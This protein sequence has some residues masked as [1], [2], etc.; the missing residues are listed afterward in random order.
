MQ[1]VDPE[2]CELKR[3][4]AEQG[5]R[6]SNIEGQ[7]QQLN[8]QADNNFKQIIWQFVAFTIVMAIIIILASRI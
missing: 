4:V 8:R 2:F 6:L 1:N 7:I 3:M 5:R